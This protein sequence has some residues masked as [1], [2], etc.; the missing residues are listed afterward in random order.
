MEM[1]CAAAVIMIN[2][3]SLERCGNA[4]L[5]GEIKRKLAVGREHAIRLILL[6]S[7]T[8]PVMPFRKWDARSHVRP[9][10][11]VRH[12]TRVLVYVS[13]TVANPLE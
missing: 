6:E 4:S 12:L 13:K 10:G 5:V 1:D 2:E 11:C 3:T 7:K 8:V 9:S